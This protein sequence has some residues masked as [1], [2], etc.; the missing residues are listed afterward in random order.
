MCPKIPI[1]SRPATTT[2]PHSLHRAPLCALKTLNS[3]L[4]THTFFVG[5]CITLTDLTIASMT[6]CAATAVTL[7]V[8][9]CAQVPNLIHHLRIIVNQSQLTAIY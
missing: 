1:Q 4:A 2:G 6:Q 9:V 5:E 8:A 7:D 3:H